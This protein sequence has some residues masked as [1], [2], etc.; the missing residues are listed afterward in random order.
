MGEPKLTGKSDEAANVCLLAGYLCFYNKLARDPN[1]IP[2]KST[3]FPPAIGRRRA[4]SFA[5]GNLINES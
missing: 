4:Q 2:Q 1:I 3:Q 5:H